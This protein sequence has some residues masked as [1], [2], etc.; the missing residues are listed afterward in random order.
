RPMPAANSLCGQWTISRR[1]WKSN[2]TRHMSL[3]D[4]HPAKPTSIEQA[5]NELRHFPRAQWL[6]LARTDQATRWRQDIGVLVEEYFAHVPEFRDDFEESLV[7]ING[8]VQLRR[9][10]GG[11][12]QVDEYQRRFPDLSDDI[13]LQFAVDRI[14]NGAE[15]LEAIS[16]D[17]SPSEIA[18]PGYQFLERLGTGASGVVYKARQESLD[19]LVAIKV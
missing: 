13:A 2:K 11:I 8:E 5:M 10:I 17:D 9:E 18:L 1:P 12:P 6:D 15:G 19:R 3:I 14:L 16:L 4:Q 7:L